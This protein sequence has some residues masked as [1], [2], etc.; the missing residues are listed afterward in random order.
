MVGVFISISISAIE[1]KFGIC[2]SSWVTSRISNIKCRFSSEL[3]KIFVR[4]E[5][6]D[7][8]GFFYLQILFNPVT[9][10]TFC[11]FYL[12][13]HLMLVFVFF[14]FFFFSDTYRLLRQEFDKPNSFP[15]LGTCISKC[16]TSRFSQYILYLQ[17]LCLT[18]KH[19]ERWALLLLL[20]AWESK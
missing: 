11:G 15:I 16:I 9:Y 4:H 14:F 10:L 7:I 13:C 17:Q 5:Q 1:K 20:L 3:N 12:L 8:T 6:L 19:Q 2:L 18:E